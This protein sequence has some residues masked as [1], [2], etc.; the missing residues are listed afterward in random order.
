MFLGL[1]D[2]QTHK[3]QQTEQSAAGSLP[4]ERGSLG[5][6]N[7]SVTLSHKY[8]YTSLHINT[9]THWSSLPLTCTQSITQTQ[10]HSCVHQALIEHLFCS[11]TN[12]N[13]VRMAVMWSKLKWNWEAWTHSKGMKRSHTHTDPAFLRPIQESMQWPFIPIKINKFSFVF[14][15]FPKPPHAALD[16]IKMSQDVKPRHGWS[17]K[18]FYWYTKYLKTNK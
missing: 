15:V 13:M 3:A 16:C 12:S 5:Q 2:L 1:K 10:C 8:I 11:L 4:R 6:V 9:H 14:N 7:T 18:F 17:S